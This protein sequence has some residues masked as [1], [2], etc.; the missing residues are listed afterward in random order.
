MLR[1]LS[2]S[3]PMASLSALVRR[4]PLADFLSRSD[5][6]VGMQVA[7]IVGFAALAALGAH[8]KVY[9]WEVPIT[10]QTV[11]VYGAGL[12]L[13]GRNGFLAMALYLA[14]GLVLPVFA[15]VALAAGVFYGVKWKRE[16]DSTDHL[17]N[18]GPGLYAPDAA[19]DADLLPLD[20]GS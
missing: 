3:S 8:A 19:S 5:A 16:F 9:L 17:E 7:G 10:L 2:A 11:A 13:G 1:A 15:F 12:V 4:S 20:S 14:A 6:S 18:I